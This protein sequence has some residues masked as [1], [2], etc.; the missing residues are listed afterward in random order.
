MTDNRA[1]R[2]MKMAGVLAWFFFLNCLSRYSVSSILTL[3]SVLVAILTDHR[4]F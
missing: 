1:N 2:R 4:K 3:S